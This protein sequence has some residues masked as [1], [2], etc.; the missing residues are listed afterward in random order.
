M[1][2]YLNQHEIIN[3]IWPKK[4]NNV[5][6]Q[7]FQTPTP[8]GPF[9]TKE[10]DF[11]VTMTQICKYHLECNISTCFLFISVIVLQH[12]YSGPL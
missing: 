9:F 12:S 1:N 7:G 8:C 10:I 5:L 3:Y 2:V 4:N 6:C 11:H